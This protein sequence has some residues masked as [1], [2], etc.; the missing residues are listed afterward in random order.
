MKTVINRAELQQRLEA[1]VPTIVLEAL[2]EKYYVDGHLPG[3]LQLNHENVLQDAQRLAPDKNAT[4]VVYC[5]S[6]T[7]KNSDI[8]AT[9]LEAMGY[10]DVRVYVAGK[11]DWLEA[12]LPVVRGDRAV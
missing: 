3:A 1:G 8:T 2:P 4:I 7:C 12:G 6:D 9:R 11:K 10:E 5:A